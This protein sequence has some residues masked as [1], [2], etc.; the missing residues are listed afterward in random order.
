MDGERLVALDADRPPQPVDGEA[1]DQI[2]GRLGLAIEQQIVAVVP[3]EEIEQAFALRREQPGP[4]RQR[5][6]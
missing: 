1:L 4:D 2:V 3:D 5:A 6:R